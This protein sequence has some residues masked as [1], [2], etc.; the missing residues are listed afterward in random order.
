MRPSN[1]PGSVTLL[2]NLESVATAPQLFEEI[3]KTRV[4][5]GGNALSLAW[6]LSFL[7]DCDDVALPALKPDPDTEL[8]C[9][10][11]ADV[12]VR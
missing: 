5:M 11:P 9:V 8:A 2:K 7:F 6:N 4:C 12:E 3:R 10:V 1:P